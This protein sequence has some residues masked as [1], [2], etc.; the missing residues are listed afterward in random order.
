M[1]I[2]IQADTKEQAQEI[3]ENKAKAVMIVSI[4][5]YEDLLKRLNFDGKLGYVQM[6]DKCLMEFVDEE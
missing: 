6:F 2:F 1:K 4:E 5:Y 3:I